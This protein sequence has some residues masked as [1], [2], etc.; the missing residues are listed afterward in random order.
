MYMS[1]L[2]REITLIL[3]LNLSCVTLDHTNIVFEE[4]ACGVTLAKVPSLFHFCE[5]MC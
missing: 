1:C 5:T 2:I 3:K 4:V